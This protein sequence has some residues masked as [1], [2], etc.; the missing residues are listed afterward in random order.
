MM[1]YQLTFLI[2]KY[3][4]VIDGA[5]LGP[6]VDN[7]IGPHTNSHFQLL[8]KL[9]QD[10]Y[11]WAGNDD[12]ISIGFGKNLFNRLMIPSGDIWTMVKPCWIAT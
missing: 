11:F 12:T 2:D 1:I 9:T 3:K 4:T 7:F 10:L 5:V 6:G 8:G